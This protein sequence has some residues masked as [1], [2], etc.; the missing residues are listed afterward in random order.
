MKKNKIMAII[1]SGAM[2]AS[3]ASGVTLSKKQNTNKVNKPIRNNILLSNRNQAISKNACVINGDGNLVLTN[4]DGKVVSYL[5]VG[6]MLKVQSTTGNRS[7]VTVQETGATGYISNSNILSIHSGDVNSITRMNRSGYIINVSNTVNLRKGPSMNDEVLTGLTNNTPIRITGK[8]GQWY[9]VSVNGTKGYVFEEYVGE[10]NS[11]TTTAPKYVS[12]SESMNN[13]TNSTNVAPSENHNTSSNSIKEHTNGGTAH[14][15]HNTNVTPEVNHNNG[16]TN[17]DHNSVKPSEPTHHTTVEPTHKDTNTNTNTDKGG[18][19]NTTPSTS[20]TVVTPGHDKNPVVTP[21]HNKPSTGGDHGSVVKPVKPEQGGEVVAGGG[22][23]STVSPSNPTHKGDTVSGGGQTVNPDNSKPDEPIHD[24]S[25]N[26]ST[27]VASSPTVTAHNLTVQAGHE[28]D[29]TMLG[30]KANQD[31][32]ITY[33]GKVDTN[34]L[35]TYDVQV[36]ATNAQGKSTTITVKVSVVDQAP[37]L[38][39]HNYTI[40]VN[41]DFS[42][43]MLG[44]TAKSANGV[45]LTSKIEHVSGVTNNQKPGDYKL[46]FKVTDQYGMSSEITLTVTVKAQDQ[47]PDVKPTPK[48]D[49]K[50]DTKPVIKEQAPV[51]N[52][53]NVEILQGSNFDN[54]MLHASATVDGNAVAIKYVGTVNTNKPGTYTIKIEAV[55]SQG[56]K[57]EKDLTVTVKA[58]PVVQLPAPVITGHNVTLTIGQPYADSMLG[59]SATDRKSVV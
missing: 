33:T 38:T 19:I 42:Y 44:M 26:P 7:L 51:L 39:G 30:A 15:D 22:N 40:P 56:T 25:T 20:P 46:T 10:S 8:T 36:T 12:P 16:N 49:V 41:G 58:K 3:V 34:K 59:A 48:P 13:Y 45:D 28:F 55:N 32:K 37:V 47:T 14:V 52:G 35:G 50:P 5:S 53:S 9:R 18:V 43:Y 4:K 23:G 6:E 27:P 17:V 11:K 1:L 29:N 2:I 24:G 54:S 21:D 57:S 31:A